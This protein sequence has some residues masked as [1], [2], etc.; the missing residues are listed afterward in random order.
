MTTSWM[1]RH[2]RHHVPQSES[3]NILSYA[4]TNLLIFCFLP[5]SFFMSFISKKLSCVPCVLCASLCPPCNILHD[6]D[7]YASFYDPCYYPHLHPSV[8]ATRESTCAWLLSGLQ[9]H[10]LSCE[11]H[12]QTF[13]HVVVTTDD[14]STSPV[15]F[16]HFFMDGMHL[17]VPFADIESSLF[18]FCRLQH[19]HDLLLSKV[20]QFP[21]C[22]NVWS[23][24][25][26]DAVIEVPT[27]LHQN[28]DHYFNSLSSLSLPQL[29]SVTTF[30][31]RATSHPKN[32]L[33]RSILRD[34]FEQRSGLWQIVRHSSSPCALSLSHY[35][36]NRYQDS[37]F[38][39]L[40]DL[41]TSNHC[42]ADSCL[43]LIPSAHSSSSEMWL[44]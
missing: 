37:V 43:D 40:C 14:T 38:H 39:A 41:R 10:S 24:T 42:T 6:I 11:R 4:T 12:L 25:R 9:S 7:D 1:L 33:I 27:W 26:L 8:F 2:F 29:A 32:M 17:C 23:M 34:F 13:S 36:L 22:G 18:S 30:L 5:S 31:Q 19:L 35:F 44:Y 21:S 16:F 3:S 20:E 28:H 15:R